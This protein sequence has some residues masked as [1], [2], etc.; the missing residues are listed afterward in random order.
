[1]KYTTNKSGALTTDPDWKLA[2][3]EIT[4]VLDPIQVVTG[5][6]SKEPDAARVDQALLLLRK[7][8]A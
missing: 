6:V 2:A 5:I 7:R 1:M 4:V 3:R 8:R